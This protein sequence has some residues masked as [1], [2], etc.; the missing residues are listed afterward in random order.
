MIHCEECGC[1]LNAED[2]G[3]ANFCIDCGINL[4]VAFKCDCQQTVSMSDTVLD[5]NEN[6]YCSQECMQA[7][8]EEIKE[9][10]EHIK[11]ESRSSI[12][13]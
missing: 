4:G 13:I 12:F 7:T 10:E 6:R 9:Q 2:P 1:V 5:E 3:D 11:I 8:L